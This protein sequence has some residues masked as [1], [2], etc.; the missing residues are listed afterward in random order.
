MSGQNGG[1]RLTR[2]E[3]LKRYVLGLG[4]GTTAAAYGVVALLMRKTF[5][6]G[7]AGNNHMVRNRSGQALAA[8]YLVGGLYLLLRLFLAK[9]MGPARARSWLY[10]LESAMLAGFIGAL[11]Y[12]LLNVGTVQ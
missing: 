10:W 12:V 5:L 6:P 3:W 8:A 9:R 7:L 1:D 11:V 2:A 4:I